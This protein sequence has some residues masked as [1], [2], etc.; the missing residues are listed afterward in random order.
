M[1]NQFNTTNRTRFGVLATLTV[2]FFLSSVA[3]VQAQNTTTAIAKQ[4]EAN[5]TA[6]AVETAKSIRVID[7]KGTIKYLQVA[8]GLTSLTNSSGTDVTTTTVQLGGTLTNTTYIDVDGKRFALDGIDLIDT[9]NESPSTNAVSDDDAQGGSP[10][11]SGYT[12]LARDESTGEVK[13]LELS[14]LGVVG[15]REEYTATAGQTV[16]TVTAAP[17]L[18]GYK[19][20]VYRNGAKLLLGSDYTVSTNVVTLGTGNFSV[21]AGDVIEVHYL[22]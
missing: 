22:N 17:T 1:K 11:G 8:N 5:Y 4:T 12:L 9:A 18:T 20:Y 21:F 3:F 2:A 16:Y 7:N 14:D 10:A 19:T 6:G 13:K 15:G